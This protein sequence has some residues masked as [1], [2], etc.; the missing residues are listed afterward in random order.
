MPVHVS[1]FDSYVSFC[2][3]EQSHA[4]QI[5]ATLLWYLAIS[6]LRIGKAIQMMALLTLKSTL[7]HQPT[8]EQCNVS[9][10]SISN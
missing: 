4:F 7:R 2:A 8:S 10:H 5:S 1:T 9:Y 3:F 6:L